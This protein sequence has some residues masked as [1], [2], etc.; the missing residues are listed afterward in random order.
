MRVA[1]HLTPHAWAMDGFRTLI[2]DDGSITDIG[3]ELGVLTLFASVLLAASIRA[4]DRGL[5]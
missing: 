5:R 1:G 2:F 3:T 4:A